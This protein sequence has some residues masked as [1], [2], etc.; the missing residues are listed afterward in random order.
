L[1]C[2]EAPL[3]S[4]ALAHAQLI[5]DLLGSFA[6]PGRIVLVGSDTYRAG[7]IKQLMG[8]QPAQ[9][10]DGGPGLLPAARLWHSPYCV[11][12]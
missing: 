10:A 6:N 2:F 12:G 4:S 5:G 1:R 3:T 8:V 9:P 7:R 11:A